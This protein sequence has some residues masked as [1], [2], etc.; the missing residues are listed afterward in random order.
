MKRFDFTERSFLSLPLYK[1]HKVCWQLLGQLYRSLLEGGKEGM[2]EYR[3]L[4][5]WMGEEPLN[6]TLEGISDRY[7][8]HRALA[9]IEL[10]EHSLLPAVRCGD[11]E[12]G[13]PLW[14]I[15]LY[16]DNMRSAHNVGSILRTAEA[17]RLGTLFLSP[18][19][20]TPES[21]K[22]RDTA[23]GAADWIPWH[24]AAALEELPRPLF[25]LE[26]C[27]DAEPL[28]GFPF[29]ASFTLAIGNEEYGCSEATLR[30]ADALIAIPLRG[31]K[32][33]LNAACAFAVAAAEIA[34]Q[35]EAA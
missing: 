35:R 33:S 10:K 12:V 15:A 14:P 11:R 2:E 31:R 19:T 8:Y 18:K 20:P 22:V 27:D 30:A 9:G 34:R 29:P 6:L 1:R 21:K 26:T 16:L 17:L 28:W 13:E 3:R 23:M 7:H 4:I 24:S 32:N 5:A 25:A